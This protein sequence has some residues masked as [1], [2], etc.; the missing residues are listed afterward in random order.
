MRVTSFL[1]LGSF[2]L[3]GLFPP[4]A[5]AEHWPGRPVRPGGPV[6]PPATLQFIQVVVTGASN[7]NGGVEVALPGASVVVKNLVT[8]LE[9][10]ATTNGLGSCLFMVPK[11]TYSATARYKNVQRTT[12][13][14]F[15]SAIVLPV[16]K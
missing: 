12:N 5:C 11:G 3:A 2:W 14:N 4:A 1:L 15:I 9:Y 7:Y 16:R 6:R 13:G 10:R 8:G